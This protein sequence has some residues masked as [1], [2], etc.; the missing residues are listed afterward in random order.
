MPL[1]TAASVVIGGLSGYSAIY[2]DRVALDTLESNLWFYPACDMKRM[3]DMS[4]T[5]MQI[6]NYNAFGSNINPTTEGAPG[7]GLILSQNSAT[8]NLAN[9]VDYITYSRRVA[10]TAVSN[11]VAEGTK[12]LAYRGAL[13]VDT[14]ISDCIEATANASNGVDD[15]DV[16]NGAFLDAALVRQAYFNLRSKDV[17]PRLNDL[18]MG[19]THSLCAFDLI[20]DATASGLTDLNKY[21][22]SLAPTNLGLSGPQGS[23]LGVIGGSEFY[24]TNSLPTEADWQSSG[25]TA[26]HSYLFGKNAFVCSALVKTDLNQRNFQV[27]SNFW[28]AGSNS[29][30][31]GGL[32]YAASAYNFFFGVTPSPANPWDRFRRIRSESSIG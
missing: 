9:Y 26:Y 7:T 28:P 11:T 32:I 15:I 23:F 18:Y 25:N 27:F 13:T 2:Y 3:P 24:E 29:L 8:I 1:P 19:L 4:G 31:P 20:N 14:V 6:F 30:D 12:L 22:D 16:T 5:A 10:L 17:K 21:A